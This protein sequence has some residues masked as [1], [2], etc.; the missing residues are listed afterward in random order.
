MAKVAATTRAGAG[1]KLSKLRAQVIDI[2]TRQSWRPPDA[3]VWP[4]LLDMVITLAVMLL[5][6]WL[7]HKMRG[8]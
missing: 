2:R 4:F 8:G 7:F 5:G 3:P 6:M 1:L